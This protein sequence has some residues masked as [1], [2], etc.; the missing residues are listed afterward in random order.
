MA[1]REPSRH[2]PRRVGSRL[3]QLRTQRHRGCRCEADQWPDRCNSELSP[4]NHLPFGRATSNGP[5]ERRAGPGAWLSYCKTCDGPGSGH[6]NGM[7]DYLAIDIFAV[8]DLEDRY[9]VLQ[10]VD[11]VN[12]SIV[13]LANSEAIRVTSQLLETT[14]SGISRQCPDPL[15]NS[16][17]IRLRSKPFQFPAGRSLDEDPIVVNITSFPSLNFISK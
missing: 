13:A 16:C 14:W 2:D 8:A 6:S 15:Y 17:P 9:L 5:F 12:D 7:L 11:E 1:F 3:S 4:W 10:I